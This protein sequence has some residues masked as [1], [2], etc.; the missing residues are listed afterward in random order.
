MKKVIKNGVSYIG[1]IA[2]AVLITI[3]VNFSNRYEI[4]PKE[5][6][7]VYLD[8]KVVGNI[9]EKELVEDYLNT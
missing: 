8:G 6:Y 9:K 5:I 3:F 4:E 2:I 7:K 1:A